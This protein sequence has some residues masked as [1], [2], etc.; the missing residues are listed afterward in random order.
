M[1]LISKINRAITFAM[2]I[3]AT[4]A[5]PVAAQTGG[6][7]VDPKTTFGGGTPLRNNTA[8]DKME[9]E[10]TTKL[11]GEVR[12]STLSKEE[13]RAVK[14]IEAA[15]AAK[16]YEGATAAISAAN[17]AAKTNDA[18]YTIAT[19]QLR[20]GNETSNVAVQD[21]AIDAAIAAGVAPASLLPELYRRQSVA[22]IL[23]K[24]YAK[25]ETALNTLIGLAPQDAESIVLLAETKNRA[26]KPAEALPLLEKAISL[27]T[28]A[29]QPVPAEW[30]RAVG[31]M[32]A[33]MQV[34]R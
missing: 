4:A 2:L 21:Q 31:V 13:Q 28:A 1:V 32:K 17:A 29:S 19:L 6:A 22:A 25:A 18:K 11:E 20:L 3:G 7:A 15:L 16:N 33:K 24:D 5:A 12:K 23:A 34:Q 27:R 30:T 10:S 8:M 26:N 9:Y 14:K